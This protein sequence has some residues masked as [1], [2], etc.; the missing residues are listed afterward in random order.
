MN[1]YLLPIDRPVDPTTSDGAGNR[2]FLEK[3]LCI[4]LPFLIP[5]SLVF[6][7]VTLFNI[8]VRL[9]KDSIFSRFRAKCSFLPTLSALLKDLICLLNNLA[10]SLRTE[11]I[12][13]FVD[14]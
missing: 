8:C 6:I 12:I 14:V 11:D 3:L 2:V 4:S 10:L 7:D 13:R 1:H 5:T 9:L